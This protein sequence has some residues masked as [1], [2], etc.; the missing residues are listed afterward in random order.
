MV[1]TLGRLASLRALQSATR[2]ENGVTYTQNF[3]A[4][5]RLISVNVSGQSLPTL[6]IYDG[7]GQEL[8][9]QC[10]RHQDLLSR[11]M[12]NASW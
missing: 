2:E 8:W 4:E 6:F 5:N 9:R 7:G 12:R 10:D 3:D 11:C 1:L